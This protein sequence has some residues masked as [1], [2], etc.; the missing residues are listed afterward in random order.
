[1][2]EYIRPGFGQEQKQREVAKLDAI[3]QAL[4]NCHRSLSTIGGEEDAFLARQDIESAFQRVNTL[5]KYKAQQLEN[6]P[7]L[8]PI[9]N[10]DFETKEW[11]E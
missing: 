9:V 4:R 11:E 5:R 6:Q 7:L 1:M 10:V 3:L 2:R 8:P